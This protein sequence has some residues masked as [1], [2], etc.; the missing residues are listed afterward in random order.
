MKNIVSL[1][2]ILFTTHLAATDYALLNQPTAEG[3]GKFI[4]TNSNGPICGATIQ[5]CNIHSALKSFVTK[6]TILGQQISVIA[7]DCKGRVYEQSTPCFD[8]T[9]FYY[10]QVRGNVLAN[11][12]RYRC[13]QFQFVT[14]DRDVI[15]RGIFI[16]P[17]PAGVIDP[18]TQLSTMAGA[19]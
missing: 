5:V 16:G 17:C 2:F 14:K 19:N 4:V 10:Q 15:G 11:T 18:T 6:S 8:L 12:E 13:K 1:F 7:W 3:Y 9:T